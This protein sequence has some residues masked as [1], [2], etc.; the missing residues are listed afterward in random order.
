[1]GDWCLLRET[2]VLQCTGEIER[3]VGVIQKG[4]REVLELLFWLQERAA[5][6]DLLSWLQER[7]ACRFT[8]LATGGSSL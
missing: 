6:R 3:A 8:L 5:C 7:A 2:R 4:F 1:M